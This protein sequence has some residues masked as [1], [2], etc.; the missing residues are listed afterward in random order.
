MPFEFLYLSWFKSYGGLEFVRIGSY[1]NWKMLG[2]EFVTI[3]YCQNW[4]LSESEIVR[5]GNCQNQ[6]YS[7]LEFVRISNHHIWGPKSCRN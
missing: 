2:L 1:Q 3:G 7:E 5:I 4:K 6:K